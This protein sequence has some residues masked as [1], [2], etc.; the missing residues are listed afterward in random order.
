M[1][2][3]ERDGVQ[4]AHPGYVFCVRVGDHPRVQFRYVDLRDEPDPAVVEDTLACLANARPLNGFDTPRV[5]DDATYE[6][7]FHAWQV[8]REHI[9][10]RW[11]YASD[12]ANLAPKIPKAMNDAAE[13]VRDHRPEEMTIEDADELVEALLAPYPERVLRRVRLVLSRDTTPTEKV[14]E[15]ALLAREEGMRPAPAPEP[16]PE[17]TDDDVHLVAWLAIVPTASVYRRAPA[18]R[19]S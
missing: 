3:W 10:E 14:N 1:G 15:L 8:A 19:L 17:I 6:G 7:A 12:P 13:L 16:L 5:L 2:L 18:Y 9:V 4:G 11:N